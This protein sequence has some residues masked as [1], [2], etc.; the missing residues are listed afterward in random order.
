MVFRATFVCPSSAVSASRS[1]IRFAA[2][3]RSNSVFLE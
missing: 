3:V 1:E 2:R